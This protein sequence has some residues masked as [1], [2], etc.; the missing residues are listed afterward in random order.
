MKATSA[1]CCVA[2]MLATRPAGPPDT[3]VAAYDDEAD[4]GAGATA[5]ATEWDREGDMVVGSAGDRATR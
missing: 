1:C 5:T 3:L 2:T 4:M